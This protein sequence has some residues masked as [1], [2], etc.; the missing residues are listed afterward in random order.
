MKKR[1]QRRFWKISAVS[2]GLVLLGILLVLVLNPGIL[3][4]PERAVG[5]YFSY[6][7]EKNYE[8]MYE[9]LT[10]D[11]RNEY[12][13]EAFIERNQKIY[14]GLE[15]R[16]MGIRVL[17][18]EKREASVCVNYEISFQ[19]IA[20]PVE[21]KN[22]IILKRSLR[23]GLKVQW[24]DG[25]I[26][27]D[28]EKTDRV[29]ITELEAKRGTIYDRNGRMLAGEGIASSVG[30]VPGKL[31]KQKDEDLQRLSE[32]LEIPRETILQKLSASWVTEDSFVPLKTIDKVDERKLLSMQEDQT[33]M[34]NAALQEQ[35]LEIPG[36]MIT[37]VEIRTYPLGE[38]AAHLTGYVQ[39]ITAEELEELK[40][41]GYSAGSRIGKT[42]LESLYEETLAGKTGYRASIVYEN[43]ERKEILAVKNPEHGEDIRT[44]IDG[45]LQQQLYEEFREDESCTVAMNPKTGEV[46]ALVSTPSYSPDLFVRGMT[47]EEWKRLN[48]DEKNPMQNRFRAVWCPGSS[49]KPVI[50]AIGVT[51]GSLNPDED[52]GNE[53]TSWRKDETWGEYRVTTLHEYE[54]ATLQ[55]AL[56]YSDNIYFAKAALRIGGTVLK[57]QFDKLG[58]GEKLPFPIWMT[59]SQYSND[60]EF[61]SEIQVA[62]TGYGQ[63]EML[64]N[65]LHLAC[66]YTAFM[67]GG[68]M[69]VPSLLPAEGVYEPKVWKT[70]V[71]SSSAIEQINQGLLQVIENPDGTGH[72]CA[73]EEMILAGKTGTAEIKDTQEDTQGTELGWFA[74]YTPEAE[75]KDALLLVSMVEDVKERGGSGYVTGHIQ[76]ILKQR[77]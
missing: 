14:E 39:G 31:E 29:L 37:D 46:L 59:E 56:I 33:V 44:T 61:A 12:A 73:V 65:P 71:F 20:G 26:F 23:S 58:F 67:N 38:A 13:R 21:F 4:T 8:K 16:D 6:L 30:L 19:T 62:D 53:G 36:V 1:R 50:G 74:V 34:E 22:Q 27:P 68:N 5:K 77:Q 64:V 70:Q 10:E 17:G 9:M 76:K 55:N 57:E 35:L 18:T 42:G 72:A 54:G 15:A 41:Q 3:D 60:G 28:L 75:T 43:G 66:I 40:D 32:L 48:E 49:F 63:G 11:S 7:N 69:L 25:L 47:E 45:E 2:I 52:M 24:S 51:T